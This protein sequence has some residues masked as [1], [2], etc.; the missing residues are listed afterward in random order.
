MVC[1]YLT[2]LRLWLIVV[3]PD[4]VSPLVENPACADPSW[5]LWAKADDQAGTVFESGRSLQS[6]LGCFSYRFLH[7]PRRMAT[8]YHLQTSLDRLILACCLE[9]QFRVPKCNANKTKVL[10][11]RLLTGYRHN[12]ISYSRGPLRLRLLRAKPSAE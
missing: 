4:N 3:A 8:L 9:G 7:S 11:R 10:T 5:V 1:G 6:S 12:C 2:S